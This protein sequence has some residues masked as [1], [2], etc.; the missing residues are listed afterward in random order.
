MSAVSFILNGRATEMRISKELEK[1]VRAIA[2]KLGYTPNQVAVSLRT[3]QSKLIGLVV[4]SIAG[5][6][7]GMLAKII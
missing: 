1:K 6:F 3:G 4:E 2:E 5:H 7:F